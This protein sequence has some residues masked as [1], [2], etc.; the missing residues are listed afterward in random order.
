MVKTKHDAL[1][2]FTN[3]MANRNVISKSELLTLLS[4]QIGVNKSRIGQ[5]YLNQGHWFNQ[6]NF[7]ANFV[8]YQENGQMMFAWKNYATQNH[9]NTMQDMVEYDTV[10]KQK[11]RE[12][13]FKSVPKID[14]PRIVTNANYNGYDINHVMK[15]NP[16]SI[17][18]NVE[19][20]S[21]IINKYKE[22][23]KH[24]KR[25][26][27]N[28]MTMER[29]IKKSI[30]EKNNFDI[31]FYDCIS[32]LSDEAIKTLISINENKLTTE[33]SVTLNGIAMPQAHGKIFQKYKKQYKHFGKQIQFIILLDLL[34][35]Y[36][37]VDSINYQGC[38]N[39]KKNSNMF[40]YKFKVKQI[41]N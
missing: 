8:Y 23:C 4:E 33:I 10:E 19:K 14:H 18:Y 12:M 9:I 28:H 26:V 27:Q 35:N 31:I 40:V 3:I 13:V 37:C 15:S 32:Y 36:N 1:K 6:R 7:L 16:T 5:I 38:Y 30:E 41:N 34:S 21:H 11:A 24:P 29:F 25:V 39:G 17:V 20:Y 22:L 2:R